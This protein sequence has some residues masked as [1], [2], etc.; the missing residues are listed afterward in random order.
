MEFFVTYADYIGYF[1]S[2]LISC[3][4][5]MKTMIPLRAVAIAGNITIIPLSEICS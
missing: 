5:Y 1:G 4:F 2:M 3:A